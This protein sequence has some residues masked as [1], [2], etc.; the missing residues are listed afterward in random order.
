MIVL[1]RQL[2]T[3]QIS[4]YTSTYLLL[5]VALAA[6]HP[7]P[8]HATDAGVTYNASAVSPLNLP[9]T[10]RTHWLIFPHL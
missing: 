7:T 2:V 6:R 10:R 8:E 1:D 9:E 3:M 4:Y 5:G